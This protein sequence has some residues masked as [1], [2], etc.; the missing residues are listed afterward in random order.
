[1]RFRDCLAVFK[2]FILSLLWSEA[3]LACHRGAVGC[4]MGS[5]ARFAMIVAPSL[6]AEL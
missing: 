3:T 2:D 6:D 4:R 5:G 1:M